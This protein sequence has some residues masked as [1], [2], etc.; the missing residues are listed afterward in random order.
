LLQ[1][2]QF[3]ACMLTTSLLLFLLLLLL[4]LLFGAPVWKTEINGRG[5]WLHQPHNTLFLLKLALT[6]PRSG[7]RSVGIVCLWTKVTEFIIIII[8]ND[9]AFTAIRK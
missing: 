2:L 6:S 9:P 3:V 4:L 5:D 1:Q 8:I 7:S